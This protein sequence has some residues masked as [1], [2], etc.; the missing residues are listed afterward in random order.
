M[1]LFDKVR[2]MREQVAELIADIRQRH[3]IE[4]LERKLEAAPGTPFSC[5]S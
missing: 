2:A 5:S 4:E 1:G 3:D